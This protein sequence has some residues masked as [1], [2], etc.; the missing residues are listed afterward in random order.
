MASVCT[1]IVS[2]SSSVDVREIDKQAKNPWRWEWLEKQDE[3]IYLREIIGKLNKGGAC[4]CIVCSKEF[5]CGSRGFVALTDHVK[6][7]K[8]KSFLQTWKEHI[9]LPESRCTHDPDCQYPPYCRTK[10]FRKEE[11]SHGGRFIRTG[12]LLKYRISPIIPEKRAVAYTSLRGSK[13]MGGVR[14]VWLQKN[15]RP[16][17]TSDFAQKTGRLADVSVALWSRIIAFPIRAA[18]GTPP[19]LETTCL[20]RWA[21]RANTTT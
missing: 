20:Q 12:S 15:T 17:L 18:H 21:L 3:G 9:A 7:E 11:S 5:P 13:V 10:E 8:H 14:N 2:R 4:Y 6:Y 1:D 16:A 19:L